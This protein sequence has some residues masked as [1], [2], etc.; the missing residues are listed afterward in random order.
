[1]GARFGTDPA[2]LKKRGI[3]LYL[4]FLTSLMALCAA[5]FLSHPRLNIR[6]AHLALPPLGVL[7]YLFV[8]LLR[9]LESNVR[10]ETGMLYSTIGV[11]TIIT[12]FR[13]FLIALLS[14]FLAAPAWV[15]ASGWLPSALYLAALVADYF[16][17]YA[18]R[19]TRHY[20]RLGAIL[21]MEV[22][23]LGVL[24][25]AMLLVTRNIMSPWFLLVGGARYLFVLGSWYR[26]KVGKP[27]F[28]LEHTIRG[29]VLAGFQ[30]GF[31]GVAL[32]PAVGDAF[33]RV[34]GTVYAFPFLANF[35][36]DWLLVAGHLKRENRLYRS[37]AAGLIRVFALGVPLL[38]RMAAVA[39]LL[40]TARAAETAPAVSV[41]WG[42][43]LAAIAAGFFSRLAAL[44]ALAFLIIAGSAAWLSSS[45]LFMQ[46]VVLAL[47]G[48]TLVGPG[49]FA[50]LNLEALP[51][52]KRL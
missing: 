43:L 45:T 15:P 1:V 23:G 51:F 19:R 41:V 48:V 12:L 27:L 32:M 17:G 31:M 26:S 11:G 37:V 4:A 50:L 21:D 33:L 42:V 22:D 49:P 28:P 24:I 29:R 16:D 38:L 52:V 30:M 40:F 20:S 25:A 7:S 34:A 5:L 18:A 47:C 14:L 8:V 39:G 10:P 46:T 6:Y 44:G 36:V 2:L 13:G 9:H 3:M 35:L